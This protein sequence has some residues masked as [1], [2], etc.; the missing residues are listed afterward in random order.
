M[1]KTKSVHAESEADD[2]LRI[3]ATRFRGRGLSADRYDVWMANLAPRERLL[4]SVLAGE[5]TWREFSKRYREEMAAPSSIDGDNVTIKN[6]GQKFT[7]RLIAKLA[8]KGTVTL[9]CHCAP[10]ATECHR[11]LLQGLIERECE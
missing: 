11:F 9:L 1:L 2:G 3:L 7:L 10:D 6:H 5:L 8:D 4:Q